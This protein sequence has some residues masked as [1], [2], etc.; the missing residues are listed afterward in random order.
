[1]REIR[2]KYLIQRINQYL[3]CN[4]LLNAHDALHESLRKFSSSAVIAIAHTGDQ[5]HNELIE[6]AKSLLCYGNTETSSI[7]VPMKRIL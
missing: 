1:M 7:K 3:K 6:S 5:E 2:L 4:Q